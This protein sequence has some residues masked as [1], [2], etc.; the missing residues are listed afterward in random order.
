MTALS[1]EHQNL[2]DTYGTDG[3]TTLHDAAG[4]ELKVSWSEAGNFIFLNPGGWGD[5]RYFLTTLLYEFLSK[6]K[7]TGLCLHE[8]EEGCRQL[9]PAEEMVRLRET[10]IKRYTHK[11]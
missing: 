3:Q 4:K 8:T 6:P 2:V 9:I 10:L 11:D 1:P 7:P 5:G